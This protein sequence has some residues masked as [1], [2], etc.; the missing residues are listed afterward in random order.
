MKVLRNDRYLVHKAGNHEG[1]RQTSTSVD[2]MKSWIEDS[3]DLSS[4]EMDD[5]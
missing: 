1:P 4:D 2:H 5:S 3:S